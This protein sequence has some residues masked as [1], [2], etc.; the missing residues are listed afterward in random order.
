MN[1]LKIGNRCS[2]PEV[3]KIKS[4]WYK[5]SL[6]AAITNLFKIEP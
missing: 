2:A 3:L 1:Y 6:N 5:R 4:A